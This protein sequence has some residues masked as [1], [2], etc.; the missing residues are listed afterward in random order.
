MQMEG[1]RSLQEYLDSLPE[2]TTIHE[3]LLCWWS[4][5]IDA[6]SLWNDSHGRKQQEAVQ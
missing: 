4:N 3:K 6:I 1:M 5:L 2:P